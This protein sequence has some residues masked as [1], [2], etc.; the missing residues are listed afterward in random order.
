MNDCKPSWCCCT[1]AREVFI[2]IIV[3][4]V[5]PIVFSEIWIRWLVC[6]CMLS[7]CWM[8]QSFDRSDWWL[9]VIFVAEIYLLSHLCTFCRTV[10]G[11]NVHSSTFKDLLCQLFIWCILSQCNFNFFILF[12]YVPFHC[13]HW[14]WW[15]W[16][17][18]L[19]TYLPSVLWHY[20]LVIWPV[21]P[22]PDMTYNVFG[23]SLNL[24]LSIYFTVSR[25]FKGHCSCW[26]LT[27]KFPVNLFCLFLSFC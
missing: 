3:I 1:V 4:C 17:L 25:P 2:F 18:I 22:V 9:K 10:R 11:K 23:G 12:L 27:V 5:G 19:R 15:D 21:K 13:L 6:V 7:I 16:S 14:T 20:W 26:F 24:T 8:L